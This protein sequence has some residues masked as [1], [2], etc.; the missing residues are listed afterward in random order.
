[1]LDS[2]EKKCSGCGGKHYALGKCKKCYENGRRENA[3]FRARDCEKQR[4]RYRKDRKNRSIAAMNYRWAKIG[5]TVERFAEVWKAQEGKCDICKCV[6]TDEQHNSGV[7][8]DHDHA[9]NKPRG[10][11]CRACNIV[12][13][14]FEVCY[15]DRQISMPEFVEY[16]NKYKGV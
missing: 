10:L 15:R 3:G 7:S 2:V 16:L 6:L 1:M 5:W 4:E 8:R 11:L 12:L 13:G 9:T 14:F